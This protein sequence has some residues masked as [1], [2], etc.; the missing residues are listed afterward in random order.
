MNRVKSFI[1]SLFQRPAPRA[2]AVQKPEPEVV[3]APP[4]GGLARARSDALAGRDY[5][6]ENGIRWHRL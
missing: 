1:V 6:E 5:I 4:Q 2:A 3:V